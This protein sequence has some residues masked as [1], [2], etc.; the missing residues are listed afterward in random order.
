MPLRAMAKAAAFLPLEM[1]EKGLGPPVRNAVWRWP[2][3]DLLFVFMLALTIA[4]KKFVNT[5]KNSAPQQGGL[6]GGGG[7][8]HPPTH[9]VLPS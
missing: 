4:P 8:T 7:Q 6:G 2:F 1:F 9:P 3:G 5:S